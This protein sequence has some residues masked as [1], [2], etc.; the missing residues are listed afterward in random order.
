MAQDENENKISM[1]DFIKN[2][3]IFSPETAE[4]AHKKIIEYVGGSWEKVSTSQLE[5]KRLR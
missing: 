2:T 3:T 4:L 1:K 5:I